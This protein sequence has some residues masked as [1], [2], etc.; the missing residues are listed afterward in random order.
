MEGWPAAVAGITLVPGAWPTEPSTLSLLFRLGAGADLSQ[1]GTHA[2]PPP[3]LLS[4]VLDPCFVTG[5]FP[6]ISTE[7]QL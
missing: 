5:H 4:Q 6:C 1:L 7:A 2:L 3:C